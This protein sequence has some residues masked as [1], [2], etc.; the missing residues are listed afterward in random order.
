MPC[1]IAVE[2]GNALVGDTVG[3]GDGGML[4]K[5]HGGGVGVCN[6]RG[7]GDVFRPPLFRRVD[8]GRVS[9]QQTIC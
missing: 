7:S 1:V 2:T 3:S 4:Y 6:S 8:R 9:D 5:C